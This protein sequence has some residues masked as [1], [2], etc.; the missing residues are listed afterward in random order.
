MI[1]FCMFDLDG[2]L[3]ATLPTIT[4][5]VNQTLQKYDIP[6]ISEEECKSFIGDGA[7]ALIYRALASKGDFSEEYSASV[8]KSY[9]ALYDTDP[10]YLTEPYSGINELLSQLAERGIALAVISNKQNSSTCSAIKHFFGTRFSLVRGGIDGVP[11]KPD[12][13]SAISMLRELEISPSETAYIGDTAVDMRTGKNMGAALTVGVLWGFRDKQEL[14]S[15][16]A[17][18]II[19]TPLQLLSEIDRFNNLL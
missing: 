14:L 7:R 9:L 17:D 11:L 4:Y 19:N 2:T 5:Y 6:S 1:K 3:L 8:L 16:G 13:T 18:V 15:S 10:Y 12:P